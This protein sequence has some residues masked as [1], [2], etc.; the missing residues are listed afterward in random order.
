MLA[1]LIGAV[2]NQESINRNKD[3]AEAKCTMG[4]IISVSSYSE[5]RTNSDKAPDL[6]ST[7]LR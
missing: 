1:E 3:K 2:P 5:K 7:P 6:S 4:N